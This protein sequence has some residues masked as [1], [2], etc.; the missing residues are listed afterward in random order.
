MNPGA[1]YSKTGKGVQEASGRTSLLSRADRAVLVQI[2]GKTTFAELKGKFDKI[3]PEQL[4]ALIARLDRDGFVREVSGGVP[5]APSAAAP[6]A[7]PTAPGPEAASAR[8]GRA[9]TPTGPA[10]RSGSAD[11][12][13]TQ[14]SAAADRRDSAAYETDEESQARR[15]AEEAEAIARAAAEARAKAEAEA[16]AK[17]EA[18]AK[19]RAA[20]EAAMRLAAEARAR[21][22]AE[23]RAREE[24]EER[25][26]REQEELRARLEEE[27]R[28]REEAEHR[29]REEA[30]RRAREEAERLARE[31]AERVRREAEE[32]AR[33]EQEELRAR[34]E[35]ERRAR[36]EAERGAREGAAAVAD[37][38]GAET[39]IVTTIAGGPPVAGSPPAGALDSAVPSEDA[40]LADFEAFARREEEERR[41]REEELR[42]RKEEGARRQRE[43]E[44]RRQ[45]E[46]EEMLAREAEERRRRLEEERRLLEEADRR[47]REEEERRLREVEAR[48][49]E[50]LEA[51]AAARDQVPAEVPEPAGDLGGQE[52]RHRAE[53]V[54]ARQRS[55][56][57]SAAIGRAPPAARPRRWGRSVAV[58]LFTVLAAGLTAVHFIPQ[59]AADYERLAS[60]AFGLPVRIGN[61]RFSLWG[62]IQLRFEGVSVGRM[63]KAER[64]RA[65]VGLAALG[66][67]ATDIAW[68]QL[69]E[70]V[71]EQAAVAEALLGRLRGGELRIGEIRAARLRLEGPLELPQLDVEAIFGPDRALQRVELRGPEKLYAKIVRDSGQARVEVT[72]ERFVLPFAPALALRTFAAQGR[73]GADAFTIGQFDGRVLDG[74]IEGR[75]EL[76]WH[77]V[78]SFTGTLQAKNIN[79]AVFAPALVSEG[80]LEGSGTFTMSAR[81]P[82]RLT[83]SARLQGAVR[84]EKGTVGSFDFVRAIQSRGVQSGGRTPFNILAAQVSWERER[85]QLRGIALEAGALNIGGTFEAVPAG[86]VS[87][88]LFAEL[89][90]PARLIRE[91]FSL[92][93]TLAAP[94]LSQ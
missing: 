84:V 86:A 7:R 88:R 62:G 67:G 20:R 9:E 92:G 66:G 30:E 94:T 2:D 69:E 50:A 31:E 40:L 10:R 35:E 3:S 37:L 76:R 91:T 65:G 48:K 6:A 17:A 38:H 44:A 19:V 87:G 14:I 72:A 46:A 70:A 80:R 75:G 8:P 18:E 45:R 90:T 52:L 27:R 51:L 12:D 41:A 21:A 55:E 32:R 58:A 33:R 64:V 1:I 59:P 77:P 42:R 53:R 56:H 47:A 26:R 39:Q 71:L 81:E 22:E 93:G 16:K 60:E 23:R 83:E 43:E 24:A 82:S 4:E 63:L 73:L 34:L 78:W 5:S 15:M 25:A 79:A 85:V 61:A 49:R 13:F 28:A 54:A 74:V 89:R 57:A 11:L 36:E 29:A 68:L